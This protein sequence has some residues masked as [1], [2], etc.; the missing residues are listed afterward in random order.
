MSVGPQKCH[1]CDGCKKHYKKLFDNKIT[2]KQFVP[3]CNGDISE[4][5]LDGIKADDLGDDMQLLMIYADPVSFAKAQFDW[6]PR[7]YQTEVLRCSSQRKI[8]RGGRRAGKSDALAIDIL[9]KIYVNKNYTILLI[10]P[11]KSQIAL[12]FKKIRDFIAKSVDYGGSIVRDTSNPWMITLTNGSGVTGFSSGAA[13]GTKSNQIR[14][15]DAHEI[16]LD[17]ADLLTDEDLESIM[18]ILASRPD[19]KFWASST[20]TGDRRHFFNWSVAKDLG[21]K[22]FHFISAESPAWTK[23]VDE[24]FR[25]TYSDMGYLHEFLAEFGEEMAGVFRNTDI[26]KSLHKYDYAE[27]FYNSL[28]KYAIGCDWNK[29]TGTHIVVTE[30]FV[31]PDGYVFYKV[32]E[33]SII[34]KHE[35]TQLRAVE[36][37]LDLYRKWHADYLYVDAGYGEVQVEMLKKYG[38]QNPN[39]GIEK[40]IKGIEMGGN[41]IIR[42]PRTGEEIKKPAKAFM[43]NIAARQLQDGRCILPRDEDTSRILNEDDM[44]A[45]IGLIQQMRNFKVTKYSPRGMPTYSQD[46]EHTLVA[47]MLSILAFYMEMSDILKYTKTNN[48]AF[49]GRFGEV[50]PKKENVAEDLKKLK[51]KYLP[52]RRQLRPTG[53]GFLGKDAQH[54]LQRERRLNDLDRKNLEKVP[55]LRVPRPGSRTT[56]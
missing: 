47:W 53:V 10:C 42:D 40:K 52:R 24:F 7:W 25:G 43:V 33:K 38:L 13:S 31:N 55:T 56:F 15:Q 29:N 3:V 8:I 34:E 49:S 30:C 45:N 12:V 36:V 4:Y 21:F 54:A 51:K 37:I 28:C 20:P 5:M 11:Y 9:W 17:E 19:C 6:T 23:D 50:A 18:A 26:N 44:G 14:G 39:S 46:Y 41:I 48:I 1:F 35:F 27:C 2:N 22:E 32:V 16:Y